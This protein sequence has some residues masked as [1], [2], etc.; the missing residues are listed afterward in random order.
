MKE[1]VPEPLTK[2]GMWKKWRLVM[3]IPTNYLFTIDT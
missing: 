1:L 2:S 3:I